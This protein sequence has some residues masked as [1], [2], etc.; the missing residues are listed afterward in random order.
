MKK[1]E[2]LLIVDPQNDFVDPA[3]SLYIPESEKAIKSICEV[4]EKRNPSS[5]IITQDTHQAYHIGH[6]D[7]W[8]ES[9]ADFTKITQED[10]VNGR[11]TPK[12]SQKKKELL[13]Y[14]SKLPDKTHTIWPKHCL[15]GSWGWAFPNFLIESLNNWQF[16]NNGKRYQIIQKGTDQNHEMYSAI[17]RIDRSG[18]GLRHSTLIK[19]LSVYD[20]VLIAGF[21]KDVCVA[22]TV[23]DLNKSGYFKNK[24]VFLDSCMT[25]LNPDSEML[26]V[27]KLS[28]G[29]V[30]E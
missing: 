24:L 23:K 6:S 3:G 1:R 22:W 12:N 29:A 11:Y 15:E 25:G 28:E 17:T 7:W 14:M 5:I 9:P 30:W 21:A 10:V 18:E 19:T 27:Y 16:K 13:N 8:K 20:K 26:N 2:V 4:I